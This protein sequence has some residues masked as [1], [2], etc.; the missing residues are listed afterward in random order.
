[1]YGNIFEEYGNALFFVVFL[2]Q[3]SGG[4]ANISGLLAV[5]SKL[6]E[7]GSEISYRK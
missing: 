5:I 2:K 6:L 4:H 3:Q 1:M 7:L